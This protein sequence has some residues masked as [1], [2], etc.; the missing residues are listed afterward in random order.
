MSIDVD[1]YEI[2]RRTPPHG[3]FERSARMHF[4]TTP[5][6]EAQ[7]ATQYM[8]DIQNYKCPTNS[9]YTA[10]AY[11]KKPPRVFQVN[12]NQPN[13]VFC[14]GSICPTGPVT[15]GGIYALDASFHSQIVKFQ[16]THSEYKVVF[17]PSGQSPLLGYCS[18]AY[19]V[20]AKLIGPDDEHILNIEDDLKYEILVL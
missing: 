16:T 5:A 8:S 11:V 3:C 4:F 20:P 17:Y 10:Y 19:V 12:S 6:M 2:E 14:N 13:V 15:G 9:K 7:W 1:E 18:G